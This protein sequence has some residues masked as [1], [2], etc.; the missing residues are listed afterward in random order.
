MPADLAH[1]TSGDQMNVVDVGPSQGDFGISQAR[2]VAPGQPF[3]STLFYRMATSGT[4]HMPKLGSWQSDPL[5]LR[6]V[7]DWI[8]SMDPSDSEKVA[9]PV[10]DHADTSA[11]LQRFS[12]L[13]FDDQVTPLRRQVI[14]RREQASGNPLTAALF[15]RF[16][17]P[18][19]RRKRLGANV[20]VQALLNLP[21]DAIRGRERF[22]DGQ[23]MQ[24]SL[25]HRVQ[26]SGQSVGPDMDG[27]GKKRSRQELLESILE[28]SKLIDPKYSTHVVLTA[29]GQIV[30]GLMVRDA[31]REIVIRSADG[32]NHHIAKDGIE[33]QRMQSESL[34]PKGL[35]AAMTAQELADLLAFLESLK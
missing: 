20:D 25:C 12:Q 27:I 29:D 7:H 11:A 32:K 6:L 30:N 35:A 14:A 3:R 17:P 33:S 10:G 1:S 23:S 4:G 13:L 21:G 19:E 24:C 9:L 26:G 28:P 31:A 5:G 15:E 22:L 16:L 34:M 18:A 8:A 2:V